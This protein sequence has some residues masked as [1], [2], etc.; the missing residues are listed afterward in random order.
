MAPDA[1]FDGT[2]EQAAAAVEAAIAS[3]RS[4]RRFLPTPVDRELI[5]RIL[6]VSSRAPS[7]TNMQPWQVYVVGGKTKAKLSEELV[8][9]HLYHRADH[10]T[11]AAY[12]PDKFVEPYLGRRR[13]VGWDLYGLLGIEKGNVEAMKQQHA[14][15]FRFFDAPVGMFF[16]IDRVLE[17]GSWL[18]YGMF[19]EN[20]MVAARGHGLDTCPQAAFADFH[21]IIRRHL[22]IQ[23][24]QII[25]CGMS[26]GYADNEAIENTLVTEREPV[27]N[28]TRF[29]DF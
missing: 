29:Y 23:E 15:N 13:K 20:I 2:Q 27:E 21:K 18:D 28:F 10:K 24:E 6:A 7:G 4:M 5:E 8:D 12:Y 14:H 22:G 9:A 26:L 19:M 16:A 1:S 3:R 11:E 17:I 25:I